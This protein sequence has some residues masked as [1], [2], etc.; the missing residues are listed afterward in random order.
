LPGLA[1]D[2]VYYHVRRTVNGVTRRFLEKW[3]KESEC[4]GDTGLHFLAD[5]S[6]SYT[7][8][9]RTLVL[10][11]I[12]PHL[13]GES[14]IVW[15]SL[16]TGSTPHVDLSPDTGSDSSQRLWAVDTGG[17]VTLTGLTEGVHHAVCGFPYSAIWVSGKMAYGAQ[18]GTALG[19][20]QRL[21]QAAVLAYK[22]HARALYL[23]TD[24]G[25][26]LDPIPRVIDGATVDQDHIFPTLDKLAFP[27]PATWQTDP[28]M[29][30][31][32]K[33]PRPATLLA[34]VGTVVTNEK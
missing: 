29:V 2:A 9:G 14:V 1:E 31:K 3:A 16:D 15:G 32:S 27:I 17:D 30:V 13:A 5:C 20:A 7:D 28:R 8:T 26:T 34:L 25:G 4:Q 6:R 10:T 22:L 18:M 23:G 24:T 19:Q 12:A 33:A 11:D 21:P